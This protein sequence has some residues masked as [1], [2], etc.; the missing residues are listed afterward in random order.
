MNIVIKSKFQRAFNA[1]INECIY[2]TLR[3]ILK[4]NSSFQQ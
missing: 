1:A 3:G 2:C 4:Q